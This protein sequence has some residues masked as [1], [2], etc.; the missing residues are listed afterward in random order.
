MSA[1][2]WPTSTGASTRT[3]AGIVGALPRVRQAAQSAISVVDAL[4]LLGVLPKH[5]RAL[6]IAGELALTAGLVVVIEG[7]AGRLAAEAWSSSAT[8]NCTVL[9]C[10]I[11]A[12]DDAVVREIMANMPES[13][14]ILDANLSPID[15]YARPLIDMV[16]RRLS[17]SAAACPGIRILVSVADSVAG[18]PLPRTLESVSVR[19][20]LD[21]VPVFLQEGEVAG[22]LNGA[23]FSDEPNG[24]MSRLWKPA[25]QRL[26]HHLQAISPE[27]AALVLSALEAAHK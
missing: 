7:T 20:S 19:L 15:V 3:H 13:I 21:R 27:E 4:K 11:G 1:S 23:V 18:L 25:A 26:L 6:E 2:P 24:W 17:A 12:T 8:N 10:V 14:A 16:Q 22:R 5:A 9:D